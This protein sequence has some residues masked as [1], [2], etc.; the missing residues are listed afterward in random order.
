MLKI[1]QANYE[2]LLLKLHE[3]KL[4]KTLFLHEIKGKNTNYYPK[5]DKMQKSVR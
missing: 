3:I 4:V 1:L 2:R 5:Y